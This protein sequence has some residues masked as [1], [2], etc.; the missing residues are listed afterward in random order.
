M[1]T[2]P[3]IT[4]IGKTAAET[5]AS[6]QASAFTSA[7]MRGARQRMEVVTGPE[8]R[9][10][11]SWEQKRAIVAESV[12]PLASPTAIA[13]KY[14]FNIGQLYTWRRQM[15]RRVPDAASAGFVR[16]EMMKEAV[17]C[18]IAASWAR[19]G[20]IEVILPGGVSVRIDGWVDEPARCRT[21]TPASLSRPSDP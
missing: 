20:P 18:T 3:D 16:V 7:R 1:K 15:L 10:R 19:S 11:W 5:D 9:R 14:G 2:E 13:R 4:P 17:A 12:T 8:R 6:A 21:D